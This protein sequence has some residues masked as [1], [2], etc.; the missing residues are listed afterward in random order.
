MTF[1]LFCG[2]LLSLLPVR[3][4]FEEN[5]PLSFT[6]EN[7]DP[8]GLYIELFE[9]IAETEGWQ[10]VYVPGVW[11][12]LTGMLLNGE[13]DLIACMTKSEEREQIYLFP[14]ESVEAGWS[15]LLVRRD[16][17]VPTLRH[18]D[19]QK[20][21]LIN[22]DIHSTTL[23]DLILDME[24]T[25]EPV[26]CN[27]YQEGIQAVIERRAV[28]V[29]V[30]KIIMLTPDFP[31]ELAPQGIVWSPM[32]ASFAGN[33]GSSAYLIEAIN[34]NLVDLKADT[35]SIY[36]SLLDKWLTEKNTVSIPSEFYLVSV[37][38]F[39][40]FIIVILIINRKLAGEIR[41][42][43]HALANSRSL[44]AI[45]LAAE[46][47]EDLNDLCRKVAELIQTSLKADNF[48]IAVHNP[49]NDTFSMPVFLDEK[50]ELDMLDDPSSFTAF[51]FRTGQH[52]M[53]NKEEIKSMV[54]DPGIPVLATED[55]IPE[56]YIAVP[57]K[58][59]DRSIGVIAFQ[60]Y[61]ESNKFTEEDLLFVNGISGYIGGAV[62]RM[63]A[64][65]EVERSR[66]KQKMLLDFDPTA[67]FLLGRSGNI[68][69][70]NRKAQEFAG[71]D[72]RELHGKVLSRF[73]QDVDRFELDP[74]RGHK[75]DVPSLFSGW[76][77]GTG[78]ISFAVE[79]IVNSFLDD[80]ELFHFVTIMDVTE[81]NILEREAMRNERL[82][83]IGLLAG[84]I[85][86]DF[87]NI[88]TGIMGSLSLLRESVGSEERRLKLLDSAEKAAQRARNLTGQLLT[89]AK[90][91]SPIRKSVDTESLLRDVTEFVLR[92]T[93]IL[94][95][96]DVEPGTW[97]LNVD[98]QQFSQVLQNI[99]TNA[100]QAMMDSGKLFIRA[101][102]FTTSRGELVLIEF[103]D[104]GPGISSDIIENVFDPYF[105]TKTEGHGLGLAT[106]FSI[107]QRHGGTIKAGNSIHG[108]ALFT[109]LVPA[110]LER[111]REPRIVKASPDVLL[112]GRVLVLDDDA[113]VLETA[114]TMLESLGFRADVAAEGKRA[115][116]MYI[117][118]HQSGDPYSI[119]IMD[120]TIPG[121]LGGAQAVSHVL[122]YDPQAVVIVSSG[123]AGN[124]IMANYTQYG[125]LGV[126]SK[127]YTTGELSEAI[128]NA[129][130]KKAEMEQKWF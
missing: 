68:V 121:G 28:A 15:I 120:L 35:S 30:P 48:Y 53:L 52:L 77:T 9:V 119:V 31:E 90:G 109:L 122:H 23:T 18:L 7:G 46:E 128:R 38:L 80:G 93:S 84:G 25:I 24:L 103:E 86:H 123:Y 51:V 85:A 81:K 73:L 69:D 115:V 10:P 104:T 60:T 113:S 21:A 17:S 125:F 112:S 20:V 43:R 55:A 88:L 105:T 37:I 127:P 57:M 41:R 13:I 124:D 114:V 117:I 19:G 32:T 45:A 98:Y 100:R 108:G 75:P 106:C 27:T 66:K 36:Y 82:E 102:N 3:I 12:D 96:V 29:P 5:Y 101:K 34:R 87:N 16:G 63:Q 2:L 74:I 99:A 95:D 39:G 42:N 110:S 97:N 26:W 11:S 49:D 111:S 58:A 118:A 107:I 78:G 8:S 129:Y 1:T 71:F 72:S 91:G 33:R 76:F 44:A 59:G 61:S 67:I 40:V 70:S 47:S 62:L 4:G 79:G 89:F 54:E 116:D 64:R 83:S 94:L 56:Q 130:Q 22:G 126:L 50:E 65:D 92:G 6:D 14:E